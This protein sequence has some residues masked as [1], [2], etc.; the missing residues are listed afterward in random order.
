MSIDSKQKPN[1]AGYKEMFNDLACGLR[2]RIKDFVN[3]TVN[4]LTNPLNSIFN[5][6]NETS[7]KS[8][9]LDRY[10]AIIEKAK[11]IVKTVPLAAYSEDTIII[12]K[13]GKAAEKYGLTGTKE[14]RR[15]KA[16]KIAKRNITKGKRKESTMRNS[17]KKPDTKIASNIEEL[18]I[19]SIDILSLNT[20]SQ[21]LREVDLSNVTNYSRSSITTND[22][23]QSRET[24]ISSATNKS[25]VWS[26]EWKDVRS[27]SH[28]FASVSANTSGNESNKSNDIY[29]YS[30]TQK[31]PLLSSTNNDVNIYVDFSKKLLIPNLPSN[32]ASKKSTRNATDQRSF[33]ESERYIPP[34]TQ[35]CSKQMSR[36]IEQEQKIEDIYR[37]LESKQTLKSAKW[38][39]F[40]DDKKIWSGINK[41]PVLTSKNIGQ[42]Q[43]IKDIYPDLDNQN[44]LLS[45]LPE[46]KKSIKSSTDEYGNSWVEYVEKNTGKTGRMFEI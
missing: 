14:E 36:Y 13:I 37:D 27:L 35:E 40:A 22:S 9:R 44:L 25:D 20:N 15:K 3:G 2:P 28:G 6:K 11:K 19:N 26:G 38:V 34:V 43:Q 24:D 4:A 41:Q 7:N 8:V 23:Q 31:Q 16:I 10:E 30:I 45:I 46:N 32:I 5:Q 18:S 17:G 39:A 42:E 12:L 1:F 21:K 29:I 33:Y